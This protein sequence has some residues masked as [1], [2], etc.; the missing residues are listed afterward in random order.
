MPLALE[1]LAFLY[2]EYQWDPMDCEVSISREVG[3]ELGTGGARRLQPTP[4][5]FSS[6]LP[7]SFL[8]WKRAT[9]G[10]C[11]K[12]SLLLHEWALGHCSRFERC[13]VHLSLR[14]STVPPTASRRYQPPVVYAASSS[15]TSNRQNLNAL[16]NP[17]KSNYRNC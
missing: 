1:C 17:L 8:R 12:S 2:I 7:E 9:P 5:K 15:V 3:L 6:E 13:S 14:G 16:F 10:P 11:C 4:I